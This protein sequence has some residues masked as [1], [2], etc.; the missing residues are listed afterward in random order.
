MGLKA[1][2]YRSESTF[3]DLFHRYTTIAT[4]RNDPEPS[5]ILR[6][7]KREARLSQ[8]LNPRGAV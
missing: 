5:Q 3:V 1:V 2:A 7:S 6:G 4:P 8:A